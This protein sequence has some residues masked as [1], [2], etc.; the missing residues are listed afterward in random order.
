[1]AA[2]LSLVEAQPSLFNRIAAILTGS[3]TSAAVSNL[4]RDVDAETTAA[5]DEARRVE[6]RALDPLTPASEVEEAQSALIRATFAQKRLAAAR[7]RLE[8]RLTTVQAA[9]REAE[10]ARLFGIAKAEHEA[11]VKLLKDRYFPVV[12]ELSEI[13]E[14]CERA[15]AH[16]RQQ[17]YSALRRCEDAAFG[18]GNGYD[19][20]TLA[21]VTR[22]PNLTMPGHVVYP[23]PVVSIDWRDPR[24]GL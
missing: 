17:G 3:T 18:V 6:V 10:S 8:A 1:M 2:N 5:A 19:R 12:K 11:C 23:D 16:N 14:R 21:S 15:D 13:I 22:L 24:Y 4:L 9:E 20:S 7:E